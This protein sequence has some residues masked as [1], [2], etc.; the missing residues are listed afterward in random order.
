MRVFCFHVAFGSKIVCSFVVSIVSSYKQSSS[1][2]ALP[3]SLSYKRYTFLKC[4]FVIL[5]IFSLSLIF[6][7][8][9]P[10]SFSIATNLYTP[11]NTGADF[12][13]IILSPT[14]NTSTLAPCINKSRIKCSSKAL[15]ATILQ[16]VRPASSSIFL[17]CLDK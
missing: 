16:F 14:P 6:G 4:G 8:I 2:I 17:A 10:F 9:S 12:E 7:V 11:P 1:A 3:V 5:E 13:V 15:D